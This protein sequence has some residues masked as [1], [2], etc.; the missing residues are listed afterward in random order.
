M[1]DQTNPFSFDDLDDFDNVKVKHEPASVEE[2]IEHWEE[3]GSQSAQGAIYEEKC[4]ACHGRGRFISWA[5][6]DVGPCFKCDGTGVRK[7][8]TSPEQREKNRQRRADKKQAK[9]EALAKKHAEFVET[10]P[11]EVEF[12]DRMAKWEYNKGI[13]DGFYTSMA[14]NLTRYGSLTEKMLAAVQRGME[15]AA[16]RDRKHAERFKD[17]PM[18]P[19][20][21]EA[22]DSAAEHLKYPKL[23][24]GEITLSRAGDNSRNPGM[25]YVKRGEDYMGKIDRDGRFRPVRNAPDE[26]LQLVA[27]LGDDP[28]S[29]AQA[30]GIETGVCCCCA[31][32]LTNPESVE[33]GIG[34]ICRS[35][36]F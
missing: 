18:V 9:M 26:V 5:G 22:F 20:I 21:I 14:S 30:Y 13:E 24:F 25:V 4:E 29:K 8:K 34:P 19:A 1:T 11:A 35:R 7:F 27:D 6:R 36:W 28:L 10:Y 32:E 2:S 17:C 15:K 33:L 16:E 12:I 23:R 3:R 31:R